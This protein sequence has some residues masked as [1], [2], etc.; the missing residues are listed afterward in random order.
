[1]TEESCDTLIRTDC[2]PAEF[3]NCHF[4]NEVRSVTARINLISKSCRCGK[5]TACEFIAFL[6]HIR[7][8]LDLEV[9]T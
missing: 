2:F 6:L 1:M 8:V 3:P 5:E 9:K 4:S 7:G